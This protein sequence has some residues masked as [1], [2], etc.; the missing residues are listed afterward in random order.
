MFAGS[1]I[2]Y[3]LFD[4]LKATEGHLVLLLAICWLGCDPNVT[5]FPDRERRFKVELRIEF[6]TDAAKVDLV[7]S[8]HCSIGKCVYVLGRLEWSIVL[9]QQL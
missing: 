2:F 8:T 6:V 1:W 5:Q 9:F 4:G 3:L 7:G